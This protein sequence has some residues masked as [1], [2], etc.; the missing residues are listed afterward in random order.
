[1]N[2]EF[3][4]FLFLI[5][6]EKFDASSWRQVPLSVLITK[7]PE[8]FWPTHISDTTTIGA[9]LD[10]HNVFLVRSDGTFIVHFVLWGR[11][12]YKRPNV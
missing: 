1:M 2:K 11:V 3:F 8:P 10:G 9:I 4:P 5:R 7:P 12:K 6:S